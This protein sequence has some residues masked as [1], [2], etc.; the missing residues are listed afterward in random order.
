MGILSTMLCK[1]KSSLLRRCDCHHSILCGAGLCIVI[2]FILHIYNVHV[3]P[4]HNGDGIQKSHPC[5]ASFLIGS[6]R[7]TANYQQN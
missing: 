4:M 6:P 7:L 1:K 3:A 2:E 5:G